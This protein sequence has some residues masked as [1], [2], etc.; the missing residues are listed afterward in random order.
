MAGPARRACGAGVAILDLVTMRP[1]VPDLVTGRFGVVPV[2]KV[3]AGVRQGGK[4]SRYKRGWDAGHA[5][6]C[7]GELD[8]SDGFDECGIGGKQ[9]FDGGILLNGRVC[10]IV[11]GRS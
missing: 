6:L 10:Q 1:A 11:K 9:V 5:H 4:S 2:R 7:N 3:D 8:V